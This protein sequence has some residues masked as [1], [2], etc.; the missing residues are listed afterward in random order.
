MS[1]YKKNNRKFSG[2][3]K[4]EKYCGGCQYLGLP[5]EEQLKKK[6]AVMDSLFS[7]YVKVKPVIGMEDPRYYRN[8][9]HHAFGRGKGGE[10]ISGSY[11]ADSHWIVSSDD[12]LL[13][14]RKCQEI[15]ATIRKLVFQELL[16]VDLFVLGN[17]EFVLTMLG[18]CCSLEVARTSG[19][20]SP[21]SC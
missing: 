13:E 5:Y 11:S 19:L 20:Q 21:I 9:V 16:S 2:L 18:L 15:M 14:D 12:C 4:A 3:C 6:Q 7:E 8:K 1:E 10:I 17:I